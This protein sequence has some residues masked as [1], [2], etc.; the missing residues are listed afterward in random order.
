MFVFSPF[1]SCVL[2][3]TFYQVF[4]NFFL[5]PSISSLTPEIRAGGSST[6]QITHHCWEDRARAPWGS[7][8]PRLGLADRGWERG[9]L[10]AGQEERG[11]AWGR[12]GSVRADRGTPSPRL[13]CVIAKPDCCARA[14]VTPAGFRHRWLFNFPWSSSSSLRKALAL[15]LHGCHSCEHSSSRKEFQARHS[16]GRERATDKARPAGTL[17][18]KWPRSLRARSSVHT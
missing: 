4:L 11:R 12:T 3:A 9:G 5:R 8:L 1:Y 15:D 13:S 14:D 17:E 16:Q 10:P 18:R 2:L 6:F 7:P